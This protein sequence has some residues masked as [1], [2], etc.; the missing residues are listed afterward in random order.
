MFGLFKQEGRIPNG[1]PDPTQAHEL[2]LYTSATCGFCWRVEKALEGLEL[3]VERRNV[4]TSP[5]RQDLRARTGRTQV[6]CLFIDGEPM[7]ESLDI[8]AWLKA[9]D[10]ALKAA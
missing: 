6:P 1:A 5:H 8:I 2:A 9:H 10:E 3:D 7:F 4:N